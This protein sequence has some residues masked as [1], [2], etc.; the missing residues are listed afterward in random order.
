MWNPEQYGRFKA[1][2]EL[3][4]FDLL[5]M[6]Q[7]E[8]PLR[9][10][11]DLGCGTGELTS[12]LHR[13][14][15]ATET[16]GIDASAEMLARAPADS[17]VRFEKHDIRTFEPEGKFDLVWSN[18]AL[19]W[20]DDHPNL[21]ARLTKYVAPGGQLAVQMPANFDFPTHVIAGEVAG[22]EPFRAPLGGY[23]R[24]FPLLAPEAYAQL[25]H[26]LGYTKQC[27]RLQVYAHLLPSREDVVEW[28]KG[29]LLT[30]YQ[31]RLSA[32]VFAR[33]LERYKERLLPELAD[34]RPFFYPFKRLLIWGAR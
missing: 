5:G 3:P 10:V 32:E 23:R 6:V 12:E 22:E 27:V 16:L 1:E 18:A 25:L 34:T 14:L 21:F 30:E 29:S 31:G 11:V 26:E 20:L 17:P 13:Q 19:Q 9:R 2:R 33:F 24:D 4:F 8:T 15:G 7:R 28:V